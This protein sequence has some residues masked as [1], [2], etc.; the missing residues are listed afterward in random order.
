MVLGCGEEFAS[1]LGRR[2]C[3]PEGERSSW[4]W[5]DPS[6]VTGWEEPT[7]WWAQHEGRREAG[8]RGPSGRWTPP[9]SGHIPLSPE[10]YSVQ[11]GEDGQSTGSW[12][13]ERSV[14]PAGRQQAAVSAAVTA[15][16]VAARVGVSPVL[17][18]RGPE[19]A[20]QM[21]QV[22][23]SAPGVGRTWGHSSV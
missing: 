13:G 1:G 23:I 2:G 16:T 18:L 4:A 9:P 12:G 22:P 19:E 7:Q 5:K 8:T 21:P 17:R 14:C 3:L 15:S 20:L 10:L 6:A 11:G